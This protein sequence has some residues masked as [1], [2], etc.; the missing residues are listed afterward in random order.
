MN[1]A[2]RRLATTLA[3][4]VLVAASN[5]AYADL[6]LLPLP[7]DFTTRMTVEKKYPMVLDGFTQLSDNEVTD[8]YQ[9]KLGE[10]L[11]ITSDIGRFTL[12]YDVNGHPV[13]ISVYQRDEW[14]EISAMVSAANE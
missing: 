13:R 9:S 11:N 12:F 6:S 4:S 5:L 8:F 10:P 2:F 14:T 3:G 7:E 1:N